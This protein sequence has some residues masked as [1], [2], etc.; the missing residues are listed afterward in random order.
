MFYRALADLV[1]FAHFAFILFVLFG[2]LLAFRWRWMPW[3]HLPAA[4]W[5]TA[6]EFF[7]WRCPLTPL[8][9]AMRR[10][11]GAAEYSGGF[12][13]HYIL[14]L[15]YPEGLTAG[16]QLLLGFIVI[17]LNLAIYFLLWRRIRAGK[18]HG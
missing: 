9:N 5:G 8:E 12:V 14:P 4:V 3:V 17:A 1:V 16:W 13:E 18:T 2:G 7:A 6:V 11:S 10:A 15:I